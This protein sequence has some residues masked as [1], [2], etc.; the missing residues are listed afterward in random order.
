M[1]CTNES[2]NKHEN[3]INESENTL[4]PKFGPLTW[5]P[6]GVVHTI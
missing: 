1:V 4:S 2:E 6:D 5:S 3:I